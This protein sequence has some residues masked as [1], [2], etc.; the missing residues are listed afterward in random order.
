MDR[1]IVARDG[2]RARLVSR[3]GY[4]LT[5][6]YP[7]I[8]EAALRNRQTSFVIDGEAVLLGVDG[9]SD[10]NGLHSRRYDDEVQL[11]AFDL[12]ALGAR[13]GRYPTMCPASLGGAGGSKLIRSRSTTIGPRRTCECIAVMY[14]PIIPMNIN[15]TPEKKKRAMMMVCVPAGA[16]CRVTNANRKVKSA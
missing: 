16:A 15:W 6:R 13:L 9:I 7:L 2:A 14:S 5:A 12:L 10:F 4:D 8:V 3:N 1:L 11:Y